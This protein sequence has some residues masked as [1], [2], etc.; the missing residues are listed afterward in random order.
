MSTLVTSTK[1]F[2]IKCWYFSFTFGSHTSF[3]KTPPRDYI[4]YTTLKC[5]FSSNTL[6]NTKIN[7]I[8]N[9][10]LINID[11]DFNKETYMTFSSSTRMSQLWAAHDS[12]CTQQMFRAE[13]Q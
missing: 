10:G 9:Y 4:D 1:L 3:L 8:L 5:I 6:L 13:S 12:V 2:V 11:R 7:K